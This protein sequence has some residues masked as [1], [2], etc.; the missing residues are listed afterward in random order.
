MIVAHW[1]R[2]SSPNC[3]DQSPRRKIV[4]QLF[5]KLPVFYGTRR[6]VTVFKKPANDPYPEPDESSPHPH[7]QY[8]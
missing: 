2:N 6:F 1:S 7:T 8:F 3:I 4:N 5:R